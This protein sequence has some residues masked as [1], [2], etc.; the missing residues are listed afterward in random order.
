MPA[1]DT[2]RASQSYAIECGGGARYA[3]FN[4]STLSNP[5]D[6][7]PDMWYARPMH[8][9]PAF[10]HARSFQTAAAAEAW[11]RARHTGAERLDPI[12]A[13]VSR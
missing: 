8:P 7:R 12:L 9:L 5:A 4:A 11:A 10:S 13:P 2:D 6:A 3:I 1:T